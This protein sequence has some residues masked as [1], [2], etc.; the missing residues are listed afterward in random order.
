MCCI[1]TCPIRVRALPQCVPGRR[2]IEMGLVR[3]DD[4]VKRA[5][6]RARGA[7]GRAEETELMCLDRQGRWLPG[8]PEAHLGASEVVLS[9]A[10]YHAQHQHQGQH[11]RH[12][13]VHHQ[14]CSQGGRRGQWGVRGGQQKYDSRA[15]G[16][17]LCFAGA[18]RP[19]SM[20]PTPSGGYC[21]DATCPVEHSDER[22][23]G[24]V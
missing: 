22:P 6:R 4:T 21:R 3:L 17:Y 5:S 23:C 24:T 8:G 10:A 18:F 2:R 13:A 19:T 12:H 14:A 15:A 16:R 7:P 11:E 1:R 9:A 20:H